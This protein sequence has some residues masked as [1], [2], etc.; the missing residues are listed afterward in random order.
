MYTCSHIPFSY[1]PPTT[2][3]FFE[4]FCPVRGQRAIEN[5]PIMA[6][7]MTIG[8]IRLARDGARVISD[9]TGAGIDMMRKVVFVRNSRTGKLIP[10]HLLLVKNG[11]GL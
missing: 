8:Y 11:L 6:I 2:V 9:E 3:S 4:E 1:W 10:L 7:T 5:A